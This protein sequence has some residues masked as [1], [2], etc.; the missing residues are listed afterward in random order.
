MNN[1]APLDKL[2]WHVAAM[3]GREERLRFE[4]EASE[5]K[6]AAT[7]KERME[8][9]QFIYKNFTEPADSVLKPNEN[10]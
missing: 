5:N 2:K 1:L 8:F 3:K 9:E 4:I 7:M 10:Q 6:L